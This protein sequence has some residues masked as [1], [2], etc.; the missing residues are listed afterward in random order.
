M[1]QSKYDNMV[2]LKYDKFRYE[3]FQRTCYLITADDSE[4]DKMKAE[5]LSHYI[6]PPP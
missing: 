2:Q 4:D 1:V 6:V 3:S 5:T